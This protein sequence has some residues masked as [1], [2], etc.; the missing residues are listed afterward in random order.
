MYRKL[1]TV[2]SKVIYKNNYSILKKYIFLNKLNFTITLKLKY[3]EDK[4][5]FVYR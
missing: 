5:K 2:I 3:E 4:I 1:V